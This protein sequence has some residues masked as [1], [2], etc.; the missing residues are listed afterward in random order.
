[1][2]KWMRSD[3]PAPWNAPLLGR[4]G[5][6]T[7]PESAE[8]LADGE[9]FVFGNCAMMVGHPAYRA[10]QGLVYLAG[11]AFV[12]RARIDA[13]GVHMEAERVV[14][15]LTGT[16]GCDLLPVGTARFPAGTVFMAE[17]GRPVTE[18]GAAVLVE[19]VRPRIIAF[20][21]LRGTVH[22]SIPLWEGSAIAA[23]FNALDQP[24]GL[25]IDAQGNLYV[26]DI[27]NSNPHDFLPAPVPSAVY[28]IPRGSLD[29]LALEAAGA[30]DAVERIEIPGWVNGIAAARDEDAVWF[31]SCS[32]HCP[33]GG[34][35]FRLAPQDF[36]RGALP[37]PAVRGMGLIDGI[38]LSRR[39]TLF[40]STPMTGELHAFRADGAHF[41]VKTGGENPVR[42]P[43]DFN[44]CYPNVLGGEPAALVTDIS[45]GMPPGDGSVAVVDLSGL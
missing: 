40:L 21:P 31:G 29:A 44:I 37:E 7:N 9:R 34:G 43:A 30:A 42:M 8:L 24:N 26:G 45:V 32:F 4:I 1:M 22:G 33:A 39:G 19:H 18:P 5:G 27:P 12:S 17:G 11:Q 16:L 35:A 41:V 6:C 38:G 13:Q 23:K 15:G 14:A 20:D 36:R 3:S 28:R 25:A 10:G 2:P